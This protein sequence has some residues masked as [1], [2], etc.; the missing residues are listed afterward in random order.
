MTG[1]ILKHTESLKFITGGNA[2]FTCLNTKTGNRFTYNVRVLKKS[3]KTTPLFFVRVLTSPDVYQFVGSVTKNRYKHSVKSG[4]SES[5]QSV[6][7]FNYVLNKLSNSL[8]D[9][10]IE[11]WHEGKCGKCGRQ[12]TVPDSIESGFGPE[13]IRSMM[14]R[15][16]SRQIKINK[17]LKSL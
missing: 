11:I 1:G 8:L 13:C 12:L 6:K 2:T 3:L 4:I 16:L 10:F 7:V 5:A 15:G 9:E 14:T 17:I